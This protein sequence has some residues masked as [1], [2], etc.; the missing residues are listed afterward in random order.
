MLSYVYLGTND[1]ERAVRFYDRTLGALRMK[2]CVTNDSEWDKVSAGW[3]LVD[4]SKDRK[5]LPQLDRKR[6]G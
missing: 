6:L 4:L 2:R 3:T 5:L 1:L